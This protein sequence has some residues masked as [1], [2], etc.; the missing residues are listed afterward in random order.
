MVS[1][2]NLPLE[3]ILIIFKL[4]DLKSLLNAKNVSQHWHRLVT[5]LLNS[6]KGLLIQDFGCRKLSGRCGNFNMIHLQYN[7]VFR[8]S[9]SDFKRHG[10]YFYNRHFLI[11]NIISKF[12]S[13]RILYLCLMNGPETQFNLLSMITDYCHSDLRH[14]TLITRRRVYLGIY[15]IQRFCT[16]FPNLRIFQFEATELDVCALGIGLLL[17]RLSK[18]EAFIIF[19][20]IHS[21]ER[22]LRVLDSPHQCTPNCPRDCQQILFSGISQSIRMIKVTGELMSKKAIRSIPDSQM[23]NLSNLHICNFDGIKSIE[24]MA[25]K[26]SHLQSLTL[27]NSYTLKDRYKGDKLMSSV[28]RLTELKKLHLF[29][30]TEVCIFTYESF[31]LLKR[32]SDLTTLQIESTCLKSEC[33]EAICRFLPQINKLDLTYIVFPESSSQSISWIS[34]L[35]KLECL[36]LSA[37]PELEDS[38]TNSIIEE[39]H[40]L[41]YLDFSRSDFLSEETLKAC[42]KKAQKNQEK[43]LT[44]YFAAKNR[45]RIQYLIYVEFSNVI[46]NN[47]VLKFPTVR[48]I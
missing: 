38:S 3:V 43:R 25:N 27:S 39:C 1:I 20:S 33:I 21:Y 28:S 9:L 2:N 5:Q 22:I 40:F 34:N 15:E 23:R 36:K 16:K 11:T 10:S 30:E 24:L 29:I 44:V 8:V 48:Y 47:L 46:P 31:A 19:D 18:L 45:A 35:K 37:T 6:Y 41:S 14:L 7:R 12:R 26:F 32:L 17:K 42:I 4:L 13:L